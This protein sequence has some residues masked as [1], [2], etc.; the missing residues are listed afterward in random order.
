MA[1]SDLLVGRQV[2]EVA[3]YLPKFWELCL[4][5]RDDIKESVRKAADVACKALHKVTTRACDS[6]TMSK[7]GD[8]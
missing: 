5:V 1:L 4:R 6:S 7:T 3:E 8:V 2:G